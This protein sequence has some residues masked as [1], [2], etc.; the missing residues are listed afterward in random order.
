MAN[1]I[2]SVHISGNLVADPRVVGEG[3]KVRTLFTVAV[4]KFNWDGTPVLGEDGKQLA[5]FVDVTAFGPLGRN[6]AKSFKKG[7]AVLVAGEL[8]S[9]STKATLEGE[10]EVKN[11]GRMGV[12]ASIAGPDLT[13]A[14][15]VVT[16]NE[17]GSNSGN[18]QGGSAASSAPSSGADDF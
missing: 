15:A 7:M 9:Y 5:N 4:N 17:K 6:A 16:R 2:N 11:I 3:S 10:S 18:A 8:N 1:N 13:W 12:T 14:E